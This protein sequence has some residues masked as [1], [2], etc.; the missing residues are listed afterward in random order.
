MGLIDSTIKAFMRRAGYAPIAKSQPYG[1]PTYYDNTNSL[2]GTTD[3]NE[4]GYA[5]SYSQVSAVFRSIELIVNAIDNLDYA[6][7]SGYGDD[8]QIVA[9]NYD[10]D[11]KFNRALAYHQKRYGRDLISLI[12]TSSLLYDMT[13]VELLKNEYGINSGYRWLNP[14]WVTL[15]KM[16]ND[17]DQ[18]YFRYSGNNESMTLTRNEVA[19]DFGFN[20]FDD[21]QGMSRVLPVL[22]NA[23]IDIQLKEFTKSFFRNGA[24]MA[25]ILTP[26]D[27]EL[28]Q[29][30]NENDQSV[31]QKQLTDMMRGARNAFKVLLPH[32]PLNF[33]QITPPNIDQYF[34]IQDPIT[35]EIFRVF[36]IPMEL[37]GGDE[38]RFKFG[39]D[40]YNAFMSLTVSPLAKRI[41][42]M[43]NVHLLPF[44]ISHDDVRFVF[45]LSQFNSATEAHE[46]QANILSTQLN[47]TMVSINE[48]RIASGY[49]ADDALN[50]LFLVN[51]IPVP[52]S[53]LR[54]LW[55]YQF[56]NEVSSYTPY[57]SLDILDAPKAYKVPDK[58]SHIDFKPT[59]GMVEEAKRGLEWR[60]EHNRGGTDVGVARARDIANGR[61]LSPDTVKRMVSY[62]ARHEVDKQGQGFNRGE[63][64][65]PSAGRIAWALWGGD[66]G[67]AW[68]LARAE[69]METADDRM[70]KTSDVAKPIE[71]SKSIEVMSHHHNHCHHAAVYSGDTNDAINELNTW[72]KVALKSHTRSFSPDAPLLAKYARVISDD[73]LASDGDNSI[74]N[75][76]IDWY[77]QELKRHDTL[78]LYKSLL[79]FR[80]KFRQWLRE[81]WT[82]TTNIV[83]FNLDVADT[84]SK[85]YENAFV[86]GW[87]SVGRNRNE[88]TEEDV[89]LWEKQVQ[90]DT[91]YLNDLFAWVRENSRANGG[92]W[93]D[94]SKRGDNWLSRYDELFALGQTAGARGK[95]LKW[96]YNPNKEHCLDCVRLNGRVYYAE[97]WLKY[98]IRPQS[99]RLACFG[100]HCGCEFVETDEP[101]TRGKPPRLTG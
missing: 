37:A 89:N 99:A 68:A 71:L 51:N 92:K 28:P 11:S 21:F 100:I 14:L 74:I 47:A 52:K 20:P 94:I 25:G 64:G 61:N 42:T 101:V 4:W 39:D 98:D 32:K 46:R 97:T 84:I 24:F 60:Q 73:L 12:A 1:Y 23:N 41:E 87:Q 49:P 48:A 19:Y 57:Q 54:T 56:T 85:E 34:N 86:R 66:D 95:R 58:Y 10:T 36:G 31:L 55:R 62:F 13:Y 76:T 80:R 65:Y 90:K 81:A 78:K 40:V 91:S 70:G 44:L 15:Q 53:E 82:D 67:Q 93:R 27:S 79:T 83:W 45:D 33:Q 18:F 26:N 7:M 35:R 6:I 69:Q 2:A 29:V 22:D 17:P 50:D 96:T 9:T 63:D 77:K 16:T 38:T 43:V 59:Q 75:D 5:Q 3:Y 88:I 8:E 30:Y 72:R